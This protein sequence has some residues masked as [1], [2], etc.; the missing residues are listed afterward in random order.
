MSENGKWIKVFLR[1]R[2]QCGD[3]EVTL[4][5]SLL[6]SINHQP[7]HHAHEYSVEYCF[8]FPNNLHS[9]PMNTVLGTVLVSQPTDTP[10][11][12]IRSSV[13]F[14]WI[15]RRIGG[16]KMAAHHFRDHGCSFTV[17][18]EHATG[19]RIYGCYVFVWRNGRGKGKC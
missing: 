3:S 14:S 19:P 1:R 11:P 13:L 6:Y 2:F 10:C 18:A 12:S 7:I 4:G 9:S 5:A 8:R 15:D 16:T 17:S